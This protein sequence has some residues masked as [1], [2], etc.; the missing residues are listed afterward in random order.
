M[1]EKYLASIKKM[2]NVELIDEL[3][4]LCYYSPEDTTPEEVVQAMTD[5]VEEEIT[6]RMIRNENS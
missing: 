3:K 5:A 4:S 6:D 1:D 2:T